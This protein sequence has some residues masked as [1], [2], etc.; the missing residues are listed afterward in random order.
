MSNSYLDTLIKRTKRL[1]VLYVEDSRETREVACEFLDIFFGN[2]VTAVDGED[3]WKKYHSQKFDL[4]ITDIEMPKKN[5]LELISQIRETNSNIPLLVLSAYSDEKYF[6]EAIKCGL[7]AYLLKPFEMEQF[8]D[9]IF[10]VVKK[11][12]DEQKL[13]DYK[14]KLESLVEEKTREVEYR[15]YHDYHTDLPNTIMLQ[16]DL[17]SREYEYVILLDISHF[18]VLN[19]EYGKEFAGQVIQRTAF[20]LGKNIHQDAKLYKIDSD[21]FVI[22][23][24]NTFIEEVESYCAQIVSFFDTKKVVVDESELH[25]TFNIGVDK[26]R[27]DVSET[28]IN[29]EFAL[30]RSKQLGSRHYEIYNEKVTDFRDEKEALSWLRRTRE[31]VCDENIL[32]YF[33]PIQEIKTGKITKYEVLARGLYEGKI[34]PP[35]FF[36]PP[37]E[38]LG[39]ST[40]ITRL[41][42]NKSFAFFQ[43]KSV[44][45]SI[46]LTQRDLIDD[47]L[48]RFLNKKLK[49]F[50][51]NPS[52][53]TFEILENVTVAQNSH[54]ITQK[55]NELRE[56][57]F[58][59]AVDDFGVENSNFSR[60]LEINLDFIKIDGIFIKNLK[61][62][63][64]NV[65]IIKAIVSLANALDIKTV[66][67]YVES[68]ELY[69]IVKEC[70]I[71]YAQ[72]YFIGKP[73]PQLV[74]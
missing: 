6:L 36:I 5:G 54:K 69:E 42:V 62:N 41:M 22:L 31:L 34:Y 58:K 21:K 9:V 51:I 19:K 23:L 24:K 38:K 14:L 4:V 65:K 27:E 49:Q 66:A 37:A 74:A 17:A 52:R 73:E 7:D 48:V 25:I 45:F 13:I 47:Y 46:N 30:D 20:V 16:D 18:S 50:N 71:D 28:L 59:I 39:L 64:R 12:D 68:E 53:V 1:T 56:M 3:G 11:L 60:L 2:I 55:L 70:G 32:A 44:D 33:Q 35:Y 67:E 57:G 63:E 40:S 72:G 10:K 26:I 8:I 43:D 29:C 61:N 15:C